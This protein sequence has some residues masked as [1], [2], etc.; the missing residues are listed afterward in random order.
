MG[1]KYWLNLFS[2]SM[3]SKSW[4]VKITLEIRDSQWEQ[5]HFD[6]FLCVN[7]DLETCILDNL[8]LADHVTITLAFS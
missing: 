6:E 5:T 4:V 1:H 3:W 2:T 8:R 7:F